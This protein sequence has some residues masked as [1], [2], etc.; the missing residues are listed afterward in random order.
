M[1]RLRFMVN[2]ADCRIWNILDPVL[3]RPD[4][5]QYWDDAELKVLTGT[6]NITFL[7][8]DDKPDRKR[9]SDHLPI[10]FALNI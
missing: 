6:G 9:F 1:E 10:L 8:R 5:L 4:L 3:I 7:D 2:D